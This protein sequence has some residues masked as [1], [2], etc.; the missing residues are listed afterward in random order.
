MYRPIMNPHAVLTGP[1]MLLTDETHVGMNQAV[2]TGPPMLL[3]EETGDRLRLDQAVQG[4]V[5]LEWHSPHEQD[6]HYF[7]HPQSGTLSFP[8]FH[9]SIR[10]NPNSHSQIS[11]FEVQVHVHI[12]P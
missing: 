12:T 8:N 5:T 1:P 11:I 9:S 6:P 7:E 4:L 10:S 3:T 2:L